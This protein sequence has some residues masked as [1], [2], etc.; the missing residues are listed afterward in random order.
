MVSHL[1]VDPND[2]NSRLTTTDEE[3]AAILSR[4]FS[5]VFT[6]EPDGKIL[7]IQPAMLSHPDTADVFG[8]ASG[9]SYELWHFVPF[10]ANV[11]IEPL[12]FAL[13]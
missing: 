6:H 10:C 9:A 11:A 5:I 1:K 7:Y 13:T 3:K 12:I 8:G 4:F 2:P